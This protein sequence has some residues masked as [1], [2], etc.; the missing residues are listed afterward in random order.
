MCKYRKI[1]SYQQ[2]LNIHLQHHENIYNLDVNVQVSQGH[3]S[4]KID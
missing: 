4:F 3:I 1:R 2:N